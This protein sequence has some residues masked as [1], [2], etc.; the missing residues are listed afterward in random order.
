M[1]TRDDWVAELL[2]RLS[3]RVS[4][5]ADRSGCPDEEKLADFLA[6]HLEKDARATLEAH[7]AQCSFCTGDLV[8]AYKSGEVG[9]LETVPQRLIDQALELI[10]GRQETVFR[11]V[12]RLVRGSIELIS[13]SARV[14]TQPTPALR[15]EAKP[16]E[17]NSLQVEHEVGRFRVAVELDLSEA[18][19]CQVVANVRE[20]AGEP[21]EGVRLSLS[22]GD[23]EQASFLT[24]AGIVVFDRIAPGEYSIAVSESGTVVGKIKLSLMM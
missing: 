20:Q 18:G 15:G 24:R 3:I 8:A 10:Q 7:L 13:T 9:G 1:S 14:I 5:R 12:V 22:S 17:G 19:I 2:S 6:G 23:R 21:A 11:L 16:A 4:G